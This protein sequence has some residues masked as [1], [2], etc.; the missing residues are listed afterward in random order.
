M[1]QGGNPGGCGLRR[2]ETLGLGVQPKEGPICGGLYSWA[3][4]QRGLLW[5]SLWVGILSG[6][7]CLRAQ[8]GPPG[9]LPSPISGAP[10]LANKAQPQE[11]APLLGGATPFPLQ[12]TGPTTPGLSRQVL[13]KT[14]ELPQLEVAGLP[15]SQVVAQLSAFS[16]QADPLGQGLNIVLLGV[17]PEE[18]PPVHLFLHHL[19]LQ[20]ALELVARTVG[21]RVDWEGDVVFLRPPESLLPV[22]LQTVYFP[23]SKGTLIRMTG[24]DGEPRVP[25]LPSAEDLPRLKVQERALRSFLEAAGVPFE[26]YPGATLAYDGSQLILTH[27][28]PYLQHVQGLLARYAAVRQVYIE[29]QFWEV[30]EGALEELGVNGWLGHRDHAGRFFQTLEPQLNQPAAA[31]TAAPNLRSVGGAFQTQNFT[32]GPGR[33]V[34]AGVPGGAMSLPNQVPSLPGAL[35]LGASTIATLGWSQTG[36]KYPLQL[37]VKALSQK[38]GSDLMS[39]PKVAVHS[40]KTAKMRVTQE[41]W[42]PQS[43]GDVNPQVSAGLSY[44]GQ[45]GGT[46]VAIGA[47]TPRDFTLREIGVQMEVTPTVEE[48]G[49][50][51]LRLRPEV[52][53]FEGFVEYGARSVAVS[54]GLT[55]E[56][57][58]GFLQPIFSTRTVQTEVTIADGATVVMGGLTRE[59]SVQVSDKVP[60]LGDLPGPLGRL[61]RSKGVSQQKR[62][63]LVLVTARQ[64]PPEGVLPPWELAAE[65]PAEGTAN[66]N[67]SPKKPIRK[68]GKQKMVRTPLKPVRRRPSLQELT[69]LGRLHPPKS[70]GSISGNALRT[71]SGTG[72]RR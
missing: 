12:E 48:D 18:D 10:S 22:P 55:V 8:E 11:P 57:P 1:R 13:L 37:L 62:E 43:Y 19:T 53:E 29:A 69:A 6:V 40:G 72:R 27:T 23:L 5:V 35:N 41:L 32:S 15:L 60:F 46:S 64:V 63:L 38:T 25:A 49:L 68:R 14:L 7:L 21:F 59:E 39:A 71:G 66:A 67:T 50:I 44:R 28:A 52:T 30:S 31:V 47:A 45:G 33:I 42:Y 34:G 20:R 4:C 9:M 65:D 24:L 3:A 61:F 36:G 16:A 70:S 26:P 56:V 54:G 2:G 51:H 17:S 58:S